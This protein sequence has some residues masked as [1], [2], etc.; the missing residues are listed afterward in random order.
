MTFPRLRSV[1]IAAA[2]GAVAL[3]GVLY[4]MAAVSVHAPP[5]TLAALRLVKPP[6]PAPAVVFT[7]AGG[8]AHSL[9]EFRGKVVLLNLWA[10]WCAPCVQELPALA[11]LQ[12]GLPR[13]RFIVVPVNV[14]RE[15]GIGQDFFKAHGAGGLTGYVDANSSL[16]RAFGAYGLPM[17]VLIDAQGREIARAMG[18]ADWSAPDSVE[19]FKRLS[20]S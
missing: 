15:G 13:G 11:A 14:G 20:G 7:D 8:S 10:T 16:F 4:W 3:L 12:K 18:P 1:T 19:Y 17:S 6:K 2:V 5:A 9:S